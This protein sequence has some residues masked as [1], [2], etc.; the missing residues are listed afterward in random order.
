MSALPKTK[1]TIEQYIELEKS[2]E[3][4][5]EY[6]DGEVFAMA[7]DSLE[8]AIIATNMAGS[9]NNKL[10]GKNC[11]AINSDVRVKVPTDP[12]YRYPDVTVVCGEPVTEKYLGQVML[13]NP[14]LLVE[15]LSPTTKDY[16]T[17][18]K[19]LAYQSIASFQEYLLVAQE[20]PHV[21][22]YVR[23]ADNQWLRSDFIGL[24]SVVELVSL[25]VALPLGDIYQAVQFPPP[26]QPRQ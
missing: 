3:E 13:V 11:R 22:R 10:G 17:D 18:G 8:H 7:G 25:S 15:V 2:S 24:E 19:F 14:L 6:F 16:D 4:R 20:C 23:Q 9:L 1:Y 5:Y 21:T 12:P 26:A